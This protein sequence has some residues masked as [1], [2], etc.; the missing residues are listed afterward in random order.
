MTTMPIETAHELLDAWLE[1]RQ[2][3]EAL[4]SLDSPSP[5]PAK[6]ILTNRLKELRS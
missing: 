5:W 4:W 1:S 3:Q 2:I 6:A